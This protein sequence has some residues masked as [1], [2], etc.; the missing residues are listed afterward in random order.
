[1]R[2]TKKLPSVE[3]CSW[4]S[5]C[6]EAA[7][8]RNKINPYTTKSVSYL[9]DTAELDDAKVFLGYNS[10]ALSLRKSGH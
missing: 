3:I 1:M 9:M 10:E 5:G 2:C 4:H 7:L 8:D 6:A